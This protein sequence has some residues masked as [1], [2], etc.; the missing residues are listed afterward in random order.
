MKHSKQLVDQ[1]RFWQSQEDYGFS[2]HL[3]EQRRFWQSQ[4]DDNF[5]LAPSSFAKRSYTKMAGADAKKVLELGCGLGHESLYF[6]Q[7]GLEVVAVDF[8]GLAIGQV[9]RLRKKHGLED[10]LQCRVKDL[11]K[12]WPKK[13]YPYASIDAVFANKSLHYF[14]DNITKKILKNIC[15]LLRPEGLFFAS[16]HSAF[17]KYAEKGDMAEE[18][19][20]VYN[21]K[22][23][24]FFTM[25][26]LKDYLNGSFEVL[27]LNYL[28]E[29][30]AK[31]KSF[32]EVVARKK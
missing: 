16:V 8:S 18:D 9:N 4:K 29:G 32:L 3:V 13:T 17:H 20:F 25:P 28:Q 5:S 11:T 21:G 7:K 1:R 2:L 30:R 14:K 15:N 22:L 24:R 27:Y 10:K 12:S 19:L 31:D 23:R 6:A 26:C